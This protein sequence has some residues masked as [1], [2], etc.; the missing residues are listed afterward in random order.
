MRGMAREHRA[1]ARLRYVADQQAR[2]AILAA[3]SRDSFRP[4]Q[5]DRDVPSGGCATAAW[6]ARS[7]HRR[8]WR[9]RRRD[10][11]W[12]KTD[13]PGRQ[14]GRQVRCT[15]HLLRRLFRRCRLRCPGSHHC[16]GKRHKQSLADQAHKGVTGDT[17]QIAN[18]G[19]GL[20]LRAHRQDDEQIIDASLAHRAAL[21]NRG[22]IKSRPRSPAAA[23]APQCRTR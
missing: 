14:N 2:P 22:R 5:S 16:G 23:T 4:A 3:A 13:G 8:G 9:C 10:S 20:G 1:A 21:R 15:E 17:T 12:S 11:P 18:W 6:P 7:A 19:H